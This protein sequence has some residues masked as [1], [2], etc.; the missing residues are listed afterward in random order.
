MG[1]SPLSYIEIPHNVPGPELLRQTVDERTGT[2]ISGVGEPKTVYAIK[3]YEDRYE[4]EL[5]FYTYDPKRK[6]P[7]VLEF[8]G[9]RADSRAVN[10]A[11]ANCALYWTNHIIVS[12][13]LNKSFFENGSSEIN[14]YYERF[15]DE[16]PYFVLEESTDGTIRKTNEYG[17]VKTQMKF[18]EPG[19]IMFFAEKPYKGTCAVYYENMSFEKFLEFLAYFKYDQCLVQFC[20]DTY[21]ATYKFCVSYDYDQDMRIIK[22]TIFGTIT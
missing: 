10:P 5:Y 20:R 8:D 14:F 9:V 1:I 12:F 7:L 21:D 22:S 4:H 18:S 16:Y 19:G 6:D 2:F 11:V 13:D 17:L 3:K 15:D